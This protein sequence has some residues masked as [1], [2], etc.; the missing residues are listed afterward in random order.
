MSKPTPAKPDKF[1]VRKMEE[2]YRDAHAK[3]DECIAQWDELKVRFPKWCWAIIEFGRRLRTI[4][5]AVGHGN[6]EETCKGNF[7][8]SWR[9]CKL[10]KHM[11]DV[12]DAA[13]E[14]QRVA[15]LES[16]SIRAFLA[17][18]NPEDS[19][20]ETKEQRET[21]P[22]LQGIGMTIKLVGYIGKHP[23]ADWPSEGKEKLRAD[24]EPVAKE[25]WPE[26]FA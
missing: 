8:S 1:I 17:L 11:A 20:G 10:Y 13:E 21:P 14:G 26:R 6:F 3:E 24:L 19:D 4:K 2:L 7:R 23:L 9:A 22:Y 18:C 5:D 15:L 12:Y 25:L 16:G